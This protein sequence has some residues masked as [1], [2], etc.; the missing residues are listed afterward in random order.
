M[1]KRFTDTDKWKKPWFR[2]L[3]PVHK[4]FWQYLLD[5]CDKS[6]IW[7]VDFET[8]GFFIGEELSIEETKEMFN[9]QFVEIDNG[10]RW[11][12]IDYIS[13]Q[14][15]KLNPNNSAHKN[16]YI[17]L[18]E[19]N[20]IN[21]DGTVKELQSPSIGAKDKY[22][23]KEEAEDMVEVIAEE[24]AEQVVLG[25][26][27][28]D[29]DRISKFGGP[30]LNEVIS[31]YEMN[32][33]TADEAIIFWNEYESKKWIVLSDTGPP[34]DIKKTWKY[35]AEQWIKKTRLKQI[36]NEERNKTNRGNNNKSRGAIDQGKYERL[37]SS[38]PKQ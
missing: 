35:K 20:L 31:F 7:E 5:N 18:L 2:K 26:Y 9:K 15:I 23:Y 16:V 29:G 22:I 37:L 27:D 38:V 17:E 8:A 4:A 11:F 14:Y 34:R 25:D 36:E 1:S 30:A 21:P 28:L 32:K 10:K 6:G 19:R 24:S 13:F 33:L 12:L 3:K